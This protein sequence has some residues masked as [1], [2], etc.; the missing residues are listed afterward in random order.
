MLQRLR[1]RLHIQELS[2][3]RGGMRASMRG[4]VL[5]ELRAAI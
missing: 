1:H 2:R 3:E 5:E 4:Q